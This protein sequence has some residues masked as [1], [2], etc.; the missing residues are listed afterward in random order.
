MSFISLKSALAALLIVTGI[1]A[2]L[3]APGNRLAESVPATFTP[4]VR[5][6]SEQE[7]VR[8]VHETMEIF[9]ESIRLKSMEAFYDHASAAV[10]RQF[11]AA[12]LSEAFKGIF[13]LNITG[14]PLQN[15]SPIFTTPAK[16]N[17]ASSFIVE[18]FYPTQ[19]QQAYFKLTY[20]RD[21][22]SWKWAYIDFNVPAANKTSAAR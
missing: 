11:T 6:P 8:L 15:L 22:A 7:Q 3:A 5:L 14:R 18:G 16:F 13:T 9:M 4:V 20:I 2:V 19:P 12:S 21:G 1:P 10:Q 17:S